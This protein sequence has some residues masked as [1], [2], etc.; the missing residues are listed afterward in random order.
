LADGQGNGP[1][2]FK[3]QF[4]PSSSSSSSG[5][6]HSADRVLVVA[7]GSAPGLPNWG[8]VM[9]KVYAAA[10]APEH[11]SVS[12]SVRRCLARDYSIMPLATSRHH[13]AGG[14]LSC[15]KQWE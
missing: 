12:Q 5:G 7:F 9:S 1:G 10:E 8:G 13:L 4:G 2:Y 11:R 14:P 6:G 15:R 3:L